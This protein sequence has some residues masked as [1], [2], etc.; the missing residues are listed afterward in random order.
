MPKIKKVEGVRSRV[1]EVKRRVERQKENYYE[2]DFEPYEYT[3]D[4]D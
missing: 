1:L 3:N 4:E 2:N